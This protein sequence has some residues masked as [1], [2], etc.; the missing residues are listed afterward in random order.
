MRCA[1]LVRASTAAASPASPSAAPTAPASTGERT[2]RPE[3]DSLR[4]WTSAALA[5]PA[6]ASPSTRASAGTWTGRQGPG[7]Q[8]TGR[9][10]AH[11]QQEPEAVAETHPRPEPAGRSQTTSSTSPMMTATTDTRKTMAAIHHC[12]SPR[13][14]LPGGITSANPTPPDQPFSDQA[15]P[16]C[17]L[18][19]RFA[20]IRRGPR[21]QEN[22]GL[23]RAGLANPGFYAES[24]EYHSVRERTPEVNPQNMASPF[25]DPLAM[26][27]RILR[28]PGFRQLHSH[29]AGAG[30]PATCRRWGGGENLLGVPRFPSALCDS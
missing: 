16:N 6:A 27:A 1:S 10:T 8:H 14:P 17:A 12:Q 28:H 13:R 4:W 24:G 3:P 11:Q 2:V 29:K 19:G 15:R 9:A 22:P 25:S 7:H 18:P 30:V 20:V 26:V 21:R 23:A 5:A